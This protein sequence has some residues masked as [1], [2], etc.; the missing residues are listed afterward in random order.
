MRTQ[1][2]PAI[3]LKMRQ[4]HEPSKAVTV[5][6][7]AMRTTQVHLTVGTFE[8]RREHKGLK[9]TTVTSHEDGGFDASKTMTFT[10][11]ATPKSPIPLTVDTLEAYAGGGGDT[12]Q[13][14]RT[15]N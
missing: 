1:P 15:E 11:M 7:T 5:A 8:T 10:R 4:Q 14:W 3:T 6:R 2:I 13:G 9:V 12:R